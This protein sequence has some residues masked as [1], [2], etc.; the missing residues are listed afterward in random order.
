MVACARALASKPF[1]NVRRIAERGA[2]HASTRDSGDGR[3][4]NNDRNGPERAAPR[5]LQVDDIGFKLHDNLGL[6][7]VG[8]TGEHPRHRVTF[9]FVSPRQESFC[10]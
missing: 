4:R 10:P 1:F 7:G 6:G 3:P 5:V 9:R 8:D 2:R